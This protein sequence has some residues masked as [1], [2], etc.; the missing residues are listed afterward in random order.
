[1]LRRALWSYVKGPVW[2]RRLKAGVVTVVFLIMAA[3]LSLGMWQ[4]GHLF[5]RGAEWLRTH[6]RVTVDTR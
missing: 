5:Q 3:L 6:A 1:M 2:I 4:A